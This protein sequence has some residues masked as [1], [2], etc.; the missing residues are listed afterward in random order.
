MAKRKKKP[1]GHQLEA[2]AHAQYKNEFMRKLK[3]ISVSCCGKEFY[4]LLPPE[5]LNRIYATR[6]H[7]FKI[8]PADG[9]LVSDKVLCSIKKLLL[10]MIKTD[11]MTLS[12]YGIEL[13]L[14]DFFTIGLSLQNYLKMVKVKDFRH[15][16]RLKSISNDFANDDELF[17]S[18]VIQLESLLS[19]MGCWESIIGGY[20]YWLDFDLKLI[21]TRGTGIQNVLVV[22]SQKPESTRVRINGIFRPVVR[23]GCG[24]SMTGLEWITLEPSLLKIKDEASRPLNIYFQ[25]HAL[26]RMTE[27]ID[28][29]PIPLAH[30]NAIASFRN[31][32]VFYDNNRNMLIEYS[33]LE[34]KVGYFRVDVVDGLAV[35]R[36]FLLLTQSGTPEGQLLWKNTGLQKLD[37]KY[38]IMDKLSSFMYSDI[39]DNDRIR[40]ILQASGCQG[41]LDL[42]AIINKSG[43][44]HPNHSISSMMLDYLGISDHHFP[45]DLT[46]ITGCDNLSEPDKI[47]A[48]DCLERIN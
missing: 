38:L 13:S 29:I 14:E 20:T 22:Y 21:E 2:I 48:D 15:A 25:S 39:G 24:F 35:V 40:K 46:D 3:I 6:C 10:P 8:V 43:A 37:T 19:T 1:S 11:K 34:C 17:Y 47:I 44:R 16:D 28:C 4:G 32:K 33:I 18:G 31:A 7:P 12:K 41:L 9:H 23:L 36:T 30:I 42:Y 5:E 27:R 45:E 26:E